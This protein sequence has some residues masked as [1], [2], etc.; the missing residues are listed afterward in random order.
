MTGHV[1]VVPG[2]LQSLRADDVLVSTDYAPGIGRK[3]W[4]VLGWDEREGAVRSRTLPELSPRRRV[5]LVP[6]TSDVPGGP[7]RWL[8]AVGAH[9]GA[10]VTWLL[11]GVRQAL[12]AVVENGRDRTPLGR[13]RRVAMPV[14]GV[15]RGGFNG[16]RGNAIHGLLDVAQ[17]GASK[18]D[19]DVVIVAADPSDY[20]AFQALR[21]EKHDRP[22]PSTLEKRAR[23]LAFLARADRLAV[24][25]GAGTGVAAGLPT[26]GGLLKELASRL[27]MATTTEFEKLG[28]LD[29]AEVLRRAAESRE[30][31]KAQSQRR[32]NPLG[33]LVAEVI[34]RPQRYALSHILL[35]ALDADQ[36]ITTNFDRLYEQAVSAIGGEQ[37]LVVLPDTEPADLD[38]W[39]GRR[40]WLLKLH[41]DVEDP[42][43]IVLDRRSFVRYDASR[44]PLGGVLQTTLL[45]K[46]LL[47]VGASMT[48][49]NVI[50]LVHEVAELTQSGGKRSFGTVLSLSA[51]PLRQQLWD[52]E[53]KYV[54]FGSPRNDDSE[55]ARDLE[56]F[57]DRIAMLAA[58]RSRHL[59]DPRYREL[60]Q[61]DAER[62][63]ADRLVSLSQE[64]SRLPA[65]ATNGWRDVT[66][67]LHRLGAPTATTLAGSASLVPVPESPLSEGAIWRFAL[68]YNAYQR[69]GGFE[70]VAA[71][72]NEALEEYRRYGRL[73]NDLTEAR[74]AL[75][76]EQ[77]RWR[78]FGYSPDDDTLDYLRAL[79]LRIGE[80]SGGKVSVV[81]PSD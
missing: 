20:S 42:R 15:G 9:E 38:G 48:D 77:R 58:P 10:D 40:P 61:S 46:H 23:R 45:T 19:L 44:R 30:E 28:A 8:V 75:F 7:N 34:G 76:F 37:P 32:V 12:E 52:P 24:F 26:W 18:H 81:S 54:D 78:H 3:W 6:S 17:S 71:V 33:E 60:L 1:F 11:D 67:A 25:M 47:V 22:L 2:N 39:G 13:R 56:V 79:V 5:A 36:V 59:L 68:T 63:L 29:S 49:D 51:D 41:G 4:P 74:I 80:L 62:E 73:P 31:K 64:L 50:R 16:Q 66:E 21:S 57:L 43:S 72:G 55:A 53:F 27:E 14:M 65:T 70:P 69:H 35:A